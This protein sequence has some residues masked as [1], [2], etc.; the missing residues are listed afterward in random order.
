MA[1]EVLN[2]Q[3]QHWEE[4][5]SQRPEMFGAQPSFSARKAAATFQ[6]EGRSKLLELG[7]GQGRDTIFFA[8]SGF[9]I[10][11]LDYC[12][13]GIEAITRKAG[14][15][16]LSQSVAARRHDIRE[17]LPFD[18]ATFDG[19]Y[20]H[21]LYCMAL[22]TPELALLSKEI[23]RV[24]KP[25][26]LNVYT[27]RHTGDPHCGMGVHRGE[28]MYEVGGFI[29]HFFSKQKVED[30]AK[31]YEIVSIEEF[32]EGRLPRKLFLVMLRKM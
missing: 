31:G 20:S 15:L 3:R 1:K 32:E 17:P 2:A 8:Q 6:K 23:S 24:L 10:Q 13:S 14:Q 7:A 5:F 30:L 18:A 4:S 28:E 27:V 9:E 12:E 19:C 16:G 25:G 11:A 29:V 21:M 26:G 22:T